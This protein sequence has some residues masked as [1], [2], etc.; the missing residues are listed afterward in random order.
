LR[1]S[2]SSSRPSLAESLKPSG[3]P[4]VRPS[5]SSSTE[6]LLLYSQCVTAS[7]RRCGGSKA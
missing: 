7:G 5:K 3:I 4:G 6:P 2:K 1:P